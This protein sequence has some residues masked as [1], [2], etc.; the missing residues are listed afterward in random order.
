[1]FRARS[2]DGRLS[3]IG[4]LTTT[5]AENADSEKGIPSFGYDV[6]RRG[7]LRQ[8]V[9]PRRWRIRIEDFDHGEGEWTIVK[10]KANEE[11]VVVLTLPQG[12]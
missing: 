1:M 12:R 2:V 6:N 3:A 4:S 7:E 10:P 5:D 11:R 8:K 9:T